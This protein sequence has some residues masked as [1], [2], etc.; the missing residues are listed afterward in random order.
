MFQL[1]RV[2]TIIFKSVSEISMC[3][4]RIS[5]KRELASGKERIGVSPLLHAPR[6][7]HARSRLQNSPYLARVRWNAAARKGSGLS[8]KM[9]SGIGETPAPLI[10]P[11][12]G[13]VRLAR[14]L[15]AI[16][17]LARLARV[18]SALRAKYL[19]KKRDC[20]TVYTRSRSFWGR[21]AS[22][23][24]RRLSVWVRQPTVF[25]PANVSAN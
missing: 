12:S 6:N 1:H 7:F 8:V 22:P 16:R 4:A 19:E 10:S 17:G 2:S 25:I 3:S 18:L 20:F 24:D 5:G 13:I 9:A 15:S 14:G 23:N 21:R 11:C